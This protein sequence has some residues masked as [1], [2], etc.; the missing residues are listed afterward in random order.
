M[1][2][3]DGGQIKLDIKPLVG[4]QHKDALFQ[5]YS[6]NNQDKIRRSFRLPPILV[7][8]ADDYTRAC[9]SEDTETLTE[10]GWKKYY[11][12]EEN[13]KIATYNP[14]NKTL[15]Y[16]K[17]SDPIFLYDYEGEMIRF[18]NRNNDILVTPD[19]KMFF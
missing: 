14:E 16:H 2:G 8:R 10:N 1:E 18:I 5:E 17:P 11:E 15:E 7:G 4:S 3:E 12:I 13:E 19:H 6:K 9:Y